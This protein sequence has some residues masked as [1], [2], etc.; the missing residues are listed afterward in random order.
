MIAGSLLGIAAGKPSWPD[1]DT[2]KALPWVER[3]TGLS[4]A[5][6]Q[7][8][9]VRVALSLKASVITGWRI[10]AASL[11]LFAAANGAHAEDGAAVSG[12]AGLYAGAFAGFGKTANRIVDVAGFNERRLHSALGYMSPNRFEEKQSRKPV[13]PAA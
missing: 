8:Y 6:G 1:I 4:L 5:P 10:A 7:A 11:F 9:A 13:K 3:K 12:A 2:D